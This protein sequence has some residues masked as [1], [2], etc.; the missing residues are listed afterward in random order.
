MCYV[1]PTVRPRTCYRPKVLERLF[2]A[3]GYGSDIPFRPSAEVK[4]R[5]TKAPNARNC[6]APTHSSPQPRKALKFLP[7]GLWLLVP[8][9]AGHLV[10]P[11]FVSGR[12]GCFSML[13]QIL[14]PALPCS[15]GV[16]SKGFLQH[17]LLLYGGGS[18]AWPRQR[19]PACAGSTLRQA[20][21][22]RASREASWQACDEG[23]G[24]GG[25]GWQRLSRPPFRFA[26]RRGRV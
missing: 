22:V 23:L 15:G 8:W 24:T 21:S 5:N 2:G 25:S 7:R 11:A 1:A 4:A 14:N 6:K 3:S 19:S 26:A 20:R 16:L 12:R 17:K 9:T 13:L 10:Q 18:A